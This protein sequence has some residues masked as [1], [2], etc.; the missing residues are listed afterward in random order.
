MSQVVSTANH[1]LYSSASGKSSSADPCIRGENMISYRYHFSWEGM[2]NEQKRSTSV[3]APVGHQGARIEIQQR[4]AA[5]IN[6][7][8][9]VAALFGLAGALYAAVATQAGGW[10]IS[11]PIIAFVLIASSLVT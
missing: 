5:M 8:L 4:Q 10:A 9:G 11:L 6:G 2:M 1:S 7:W 3:V